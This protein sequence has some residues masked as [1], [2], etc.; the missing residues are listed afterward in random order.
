MHA[1]DDTDTV[2]AIAGALL[3]AAHGA[4]AL[5]AE[6]T[7]A[8]HGW[9]GLRADDLRDLARRVADRGAADAAVHRLPDELTEVAE[10]HRRWWRRH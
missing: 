8:V 10:G 3:G 7:E 9:P 5:P 4:S 1:G 6:W 2:A